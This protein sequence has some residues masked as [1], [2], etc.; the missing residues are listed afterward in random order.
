MK[1]KL[2]FAALLLVLMAGCGGG[3]KSDVSIFMM[4]K[5]GVPTEA[6]NKLEAGLKQQFGESPSIALQGSPMYNPQKLLVELAAG[7]H[8][9]VIVPKADF[10]LYA[11]KG[12]FPELDDV[13]N[14]ADYPEGVVEV[15]ADPQDPDVK[16]GKYFMGVPLAGS[17]RMKEIGMDR[18]DL[19]AFVLPRASHLDQAKQVLKVLAE[20]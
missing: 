10:E 20:K 9:I 16:P 14:R 3:P 11:Q 2:V 13:L 15:K 17:K 18:E 4:S 12:G 8:G 6:V 5:S 7:E 19:Y 1:L